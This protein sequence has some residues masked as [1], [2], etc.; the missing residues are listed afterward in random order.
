MY[1]RR[2]LT[3]AGVLLSI[4]FS[5]PHFRRPLLLAPE[6]AWGMQHTMHGPDGSLQYSFDAMR[7]GSRKLDDK[8]VQLPSYNPGMHA[9]SAGTMQSHIDQEDFLSFMEV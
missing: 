2:V 9:T 7:K 1:G 4:S 3:P 5:Q 8:P 6:F